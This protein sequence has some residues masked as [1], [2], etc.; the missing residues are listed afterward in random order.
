MEILVLILIV[1]A[2]VA[3]VL[4]NHKNSALVLEG[5]EFAVAADARAVTSALHA[6]YCQGAKAKV[7]TMAFG[8]KVTPTADGLLYDTKVGDIGQVVVR[9]AGSE[10]VVRVH[11]S[12]LFVGHPWAIRPHRGLVALS[13]AISHGICRMLGVVPNAARL[14]RLHAAMEG[15]VN[16]QL[17]KA[18]AASVS[19]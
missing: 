5:L 9:G 2:M 8:V 10:S 11:A 1:G 15:R 3:G 13:V 17:A 14:K 6:G 4:N 19:A 16:K 12:D 18:A 7:V